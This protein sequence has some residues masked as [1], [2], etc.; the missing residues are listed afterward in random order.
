MTERKL[1]DIYE[2][3]QRQL[4]EIQ[5]WKCGMMDKVREEARRKT[6]MIR[7]TYMI[8]EMECK[9]KDV[10][11]KLLKSQLTTSQTPHIT[12][13][14]FTPND[15]GLSYFIEEDH[16]TMYPNIKLFT[17]EEIQEELDKEGKNG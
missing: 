10:A 11:D 15:I 2:E 7:D 17:W 13:Y 6:S 1:V 4:E 5:A 9:F 3:S 14:E 8:D 16:C 12:D